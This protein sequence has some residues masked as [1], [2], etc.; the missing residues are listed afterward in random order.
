[1]GYT[2]GRVVV[3]IKRGCCVTKGLQKQGRRERGGESER[4]KKESE[5]GLKRG[6]FIIIINSVGYT[7]GR[8]VYRV[9]RCCSGEREDSRGGKQ[10]RDEERKREIAM[11]HVSPKHAL[12]SSSSSTAK[13][14]DTQVAVSFIESDVAA[15]S[16][17]GSSERL[18]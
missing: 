13:W 15:A 18:V 10:E 17:A 1:M 5:S 6:A 2:S 7:S 14:G 16:S 8:M 3:R 11:Q 12:S 9:E 4:G